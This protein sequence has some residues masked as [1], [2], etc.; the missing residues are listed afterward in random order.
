MTDF[1]VSQISS[2]FLSF[3]FL[4]FFSLK[5]LFVFTYFLQ[6]KAVY[7]NFSSV[8]SNLTHVGHRASSSHIEDELGGG[9]GPVSEFS[10]STGSFHWSVPLLSQ[11][12]GLALWARRKKIRRRRGARV[13]DSSGL[14]THRARRD[15]YGSPEP[16]DRSAS[17]RR[18]DPLEKLH[19]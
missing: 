5:K 12:P 15:A 8:L 19:F 7:N 9:S 11:E 16:L 2:F 13:G 1:V 10:I 17:T 6:F 4:S 3:I 14:E 18:A